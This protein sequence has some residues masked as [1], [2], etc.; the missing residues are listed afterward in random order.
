LT[1]V[2]NSRT[3]KSSGKT[4][5]QSRFDL[6]SAHPDEPS[7]AQRQALVRGHWGGVEIRNHWRRDALW[8]EAKSRTRNPNVPAKLALVRNAPFALRP[9]HHPDTPLPQMKERLQS[10]P[11]ACLQLIRS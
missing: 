10:R 6:S 8:R 9:E 5:P 7:P 4:S 2:R 11:G 3:Q 1:V